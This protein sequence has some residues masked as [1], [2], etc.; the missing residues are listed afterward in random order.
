MLLITKFHK[1]FTENRERIV[2][3]LMNNYCSEFSLL[4]FTKNVSIYSRMDNVGKSS[5]SYELSYK[6]KLYILLYDFES[7]LVLNV[8]IATEWNETELEEALPELDIPIVLDEA[9][10]FQYSLLNDIRD[11]P[12]ALYRAVL[13]FTF[14]VHDEVQKKM[15]YYSLEQFYLYE[16]R[17]YRFLEDKITFYS[18][19]NC[20]Y[21]PCP[22]V[23]IEILKE[24]G[25]KF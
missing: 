15:E 19:W 8:E 9:E 4:N 25:Q 18:S 20:S 24:K 7:P 14:S 13:D 11:L 12:Y 2:E 16:G 23:T 10:F 3:L 21:H 5:M 6:D 1:Y 17:L 22:H